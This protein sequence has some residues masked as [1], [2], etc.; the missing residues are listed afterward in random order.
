[1]GRYLKINNLHVL[2]SGVES[3]NTFLVPRQDDR[4]CLQRIKDQDSM[5]PSSQSSLPILHAY[6]HLY[7]ALLR[8]V[9]YSTPN[10]YVARDQL[11]DAFRRGHYEQFDK[12]KISRT[13]EFLD[14]ATRERGLEHRLLKNLLH[15]A[16][17]RILNLKKLV[18]QSV[19]RLSLVYIYG[20]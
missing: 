19:H 6:R 20:S 14:A 1:V 13:L 8:A 18:S 3:R 12:Q 9:Q 17:W 2:K 10:R 5:L 4:N 15:V 7:R 11:R 16:Y